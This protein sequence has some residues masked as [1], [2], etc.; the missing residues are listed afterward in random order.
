MAKVIGIKP[1]VFDFTDKNGKK[2][3]S[4]GLTLYLTYESKSVEGLA[5]ESVYLSNAK[6]NGYDAY[7]GDEVEVLYN[8]FGKASGIRLVSA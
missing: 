1:T 7:L 2:V 4:E 8:K 5:C 3:N 6:L